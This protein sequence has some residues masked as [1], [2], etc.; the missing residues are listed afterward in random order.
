MHLTLNARDA[1][2]AGGCIQIS[3]AAVQVEPGVTNHAEA[4]LGAFVRPGVS[5][6]GVGMNA[7]R[8]G[9]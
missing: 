5:D 8:G 1:M 4:R 7:P 6:T 3:T 2:S 9:N